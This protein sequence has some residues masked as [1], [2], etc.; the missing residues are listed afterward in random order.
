MEI[1][2]SVVNDKWVIYP[3]ILSAP[4]IIVGHFAGLPWLAILGCLMLLP[5][6]VVG[7]VG[8]IWVLINS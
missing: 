1:P 2:H 6:A 7:L 5:F 3:L 4:T 8:F